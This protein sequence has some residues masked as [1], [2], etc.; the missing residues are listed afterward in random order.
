MKALGID[1]KEFWLNHWPEGMY[2]EDNEKALMD[3]VTGEPKLEDA[4]K[5]DLSRFGYLLNNQGATGDESTFETHFRRWMKKRDSVTVVVTVPRGKE[6]EC[7]G[8][9]TQ[10]GWKAVKA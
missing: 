3:E 1:I 6:D 7:I 2:V 8:L 9:M 5:Y 10:A 4:E